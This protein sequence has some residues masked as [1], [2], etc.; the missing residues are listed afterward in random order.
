[1]PPIHT[2]ISYFI[3]H[4]QHIS[5][6][7][8]QSTYHRYQ[9]TLLITSYNYNIPMILFLNTV[10]GKYKT[11]LQ[12]VSTKTFHK[13]VVTKSFHKKCP[14]REEG[15]RKVSSKGGVGERQGTPITPPTVHSRMLLLIVCPRS[16]NNEWQRPKL[17]FFSWQ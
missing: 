4:A 3:K 1:M 11:Y 6:T 15:E 8:E 12:Q 2:P 13:K 17:N 5:H 7:G 9:Y 10:R 16:I 14:Q